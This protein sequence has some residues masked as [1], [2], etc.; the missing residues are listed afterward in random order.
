MSTISNTN[1]CD[2]GFFQITANDDLRAFCKSTIINGINSANA[3]PIL[4]SFEGAMHD[5]RRSMNRRMILLQDPSWSSL[6]KVYWGA[7]IDT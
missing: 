2:A 3:L 5:S 6:T 7:T 1:I 4:V